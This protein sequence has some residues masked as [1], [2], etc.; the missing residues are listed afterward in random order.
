LLTATVGV[1]ITVTVTGGVRVTGTPGTVTTAVLINTVPLI[2][3]L[4]A[5]AVIVTV[6]IPTLFP[7]RFTTAVTGSV[8]TGFTTHVPVVTVQ[9]ALF[10]VTPA[11]KSS[12]ITASAR[13]VAVVLPVLVTR[14][15]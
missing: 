7:G 1:A 3:L 12:K 8:G 13:F 11:G 9:L 15:V 6:A 4:L 10:N 14:I 5:V 2:K